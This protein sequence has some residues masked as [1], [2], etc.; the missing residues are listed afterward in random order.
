MM[1]YKGYI[2]KVEFDDE[3]DV[4]HGE[5]IN[6]RDVVT[7]QGQAVEELR[8][9]FQESVEDYLA[10]C[11]E[12]NEQPE[13]PYSGKFSVRI[14]TELHRKI[15]MQAR[16]ASKSLNRWVSDTFEVAIAA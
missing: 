3:D 9:A 13:R 7:F 14:D 2:A 5:I 16:I 4:F 6:L 11:A 1:E 15:A 8:H 10:F 12:R